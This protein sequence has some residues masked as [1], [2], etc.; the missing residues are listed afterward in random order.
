MINIFGFN[1]IECITLMAEFGEPKF[2]GKQLFSWLYEHKVRNFDD[3]T[4]FSKK[5]RALLSEGYC[6][7]WGNVI[8]IKRDSVDNTKKFLIGFADSNTI[9]SVLMQY[10]HGYSICVSSQAGCRMGCAFCAS[11]R[12]G[13][14][15]DLNAG[16]IL[17]QLFLA[18]EDAGVRISNVVIMGMGEPLDNYENVMKFIRLCMTGAGLSARKITLSTCGLVPGIER[19]A[20]EDLPINLAISLHAAF[21]EKRERIM[22]IAVKYT[23]KELLKVCN[24]Y[25]TITGRRLTFEYTLIHGFNDGRD[26]ASEL[27]KLFRDF[28]AHINLIPLNPVEGVRYKPSGNVTFFSN[29]LK[30]GGITCTIRRTMGSD[31]DSAC[32][33]LQQQHRE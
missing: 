12:D 1:E 3:C 13:R 17:G 18:E 14:K 21:Q 24:N 22:P 6:I 8:S 5:L 27:I 16:E 19:L 15:R 10:H 30:K 9:E 32:G 33:Q 20:K 23:L 29:L 7:D 11:T 28:P 25:F 4:N 26:D 2:R 31:I